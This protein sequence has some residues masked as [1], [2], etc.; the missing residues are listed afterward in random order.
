MKILKK[1]VL[2]TLLSGMAGTVLNCMSGGHEFVD[3]LAQRNTRFQ[4][5]R[6]TRA[7]ASVIMSGDSRRDLL[8]Q[9]RGFPEQ[10][11]NL[12]M[13]QDDITSLSYFNTDDNVK[14]IMDRI[15]NYKREAVLDLSDLGIDSEQLT[16]LVPYIRRF[17]DLFGLKRLNL[18]NNIIK[19]LPKSFNHL[20]GLF[21][22]NLSGNKLYYFYP[23]FNYNVIEFPDAD[24]LKILGQL[25]SLEILDL[26]NNSLKY[27]PWQLNKLS[28]LLFLDLS[29]NT[30]L[31]SL[32]KSFTKLGNLR[33]LRLHETNCDKVMRNRLLRRMSN[34]NLFF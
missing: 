18:S 7:Q 16:I 9:G 19:K 22:L 15:H 30:E 12:Y 5:N 21:G 1:L 4:I 2:V 28:N 27:V 11:D 13:R 34:L 31:H 20:N 32:H 17:I 8:L 10:N 14:R 25:V 29:G 6:P 23:T 3:K 26:S 33:C 24:Y